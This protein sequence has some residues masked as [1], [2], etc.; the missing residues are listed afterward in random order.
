[1]IASNSEPQIQNSKFKI[2]NVELDPQRQQLARQYAGTRRA[3]FFGSLAFMLAGI[4]L[5]L[6]TGWSVSLRQWAEG[7]SIDP[8]MAVALYGIALGALY[9]LISLPLDFYSGYI[10]PHK[11]GMSTQGLAGWA[12]DNV[13]ELAL[14]A[15]FGLGALELLYWLL[16]TWPDWWWALMAGLAWLFM[17]AMA[18]LA[19][20]LLMPLFY[21]VRP[22]DDPALTERLTAL[23]EQAGTRVRGVYVMDMSSRTTAANA[24]LTGLGRTRRIILGDTLLEGYTHD[25]IETVL[26]HEL[27]HHVHNDLPKGLLVEAAL[28]L[29]G[30]WV[31][32]H[33]LA[34]GVG[35]FGF[36]GIADVANL[37]L[38]AVAMSLFG[39]VVMPAGNFMSRQMERAADRYALRVTGKRA[40]FRSVMLKLAGQNLAEADPPAWVR[41]LFHSHP[42]VSERIKEEG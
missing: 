39:L 26:A 31:A 32:S 4:A 3:L 2:Q 29:A 13:K 21:K 34:W 33:V 37:P 10:L 20:V 15:A 6:F 36:R 24:M 35:A 1:V 14:T 40:A 28:L 17:V 16:R 19:P 30:M 22:L 7:I 18:Q 23:A 12:L 38:F 5:L 42:P 25:E 41:F 11:Y 9:T 27:A 8:W